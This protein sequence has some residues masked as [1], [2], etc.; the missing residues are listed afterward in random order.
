[1]TLTKSIAARNLR[2]RPRQAF[3]ACMTSWCASTAFPRLTVWPDCALAGRWRHRKSWRL[4][5]DGTS[6]RSS[7]LLGPACNSRNLPWNHTTRR[8]L[9]AR[10]KRLPRQGH[11]LLQACLSEQ[12]GSFSLTPP[13]ATSIAFVRSHLPLDSV[14]LAHHIRTQVSV[15]VAPGAYLGA[16]NHLRITVGYETGKVTAALS[17]I[18]E[19]V[20]SLEALPAPAAKR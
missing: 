6:T 18:G 17:R 2:A 16:E 11:A 7:L 4:C 13:A 14:A 8:P 3:G 9:T 1:C 10:Q 20:A 5:G 19:A 12:K 15:L